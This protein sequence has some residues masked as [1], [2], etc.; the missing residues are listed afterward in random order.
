MVPAVAHL[1]KMTTI[2]VEHAPAF[3]DPTDKRLEALSRTMK[4]F[5]AP[6]FYPIL[7]GILL[8]QTISD[9]S[10]S[11]KWD[12]T[13]PARLYFVWPSL[14]LCKWL[15]W[16][17]RLE[18]TLLVLHMDKLVL[19]S[20]ISFL[21]TFHLNQVLVSL[22]S[23]PDNQKETSYHCS[24]MVRAVQ[25]YFSTTA[26]FRKTDSFFCHPRWAQEGSLSF[27]L[28]HFLVAQTADLFRI[29]NL[30][31]LPFP[32]KADC[33]RAVIASCGLL[34]I[35][36]LSSTQW[37]IL[38][39]LMQFLGVG[40]FRWLSDLQIVPSYCYFTLGLLMVVCCVAPYSDCF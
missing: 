8:C 37:I 36:S 4:S 3:R 33:T 21:P 17:L 23:A 14:R 13:A 5:V 29:M 7:F 19:R 32:V 9:S 12:L 24:A 34:F 35:H 27:S 22:F 39:Y 26:S 20:R 18:G 11:P 30:V 10:K 6:I 28:C 40:S 2:P 1:N 25:V 15:I 16:L 38:L 31:P